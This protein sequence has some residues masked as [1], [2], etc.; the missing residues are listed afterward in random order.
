[1]DRIKAAKERGLKISQ[2]EMANE[3]VAPINYEK[4]LFPEPAKMKAFLKDCGISNPDTY[5][6]PTAPAAKVVA[7]EDDDFDFGDVVTDSVTDSVAIGDDITLVAP[8][9]DDDFGDDEEEASVVV[10]TAA[11]PKPKAK[12][13]PVESEPELES[14]DDTEDD[15]GDFDLS[16]VAPPVPPKT[17]KPKPKK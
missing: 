8:G 5:F 12:S 2:L 9:Q 15:D 11:K 7:S 17:A 13:I 10:T 6:A 14:D 16:F 3:Y 1:M 4:E